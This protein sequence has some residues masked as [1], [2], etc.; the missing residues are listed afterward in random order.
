MDPLGGN[1][2]PV[3]CQPPAIRE[4][5]PEICPVAA[6]GRVFKGGPPDFRVAATASPGDRGS[7]VGKTLRRRVR[8]VQSANVIAALPAQRAEIAPPPESFRRP[9]RPGN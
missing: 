1:E 3:N 9:A 5:A 7:I 8:V 2:S 6:V 4:P